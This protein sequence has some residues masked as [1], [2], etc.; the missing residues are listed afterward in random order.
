MK[1]EKGTAGGDS[2][3]CSHHGGSSASN[4]GAQPLQKDKYSEAIHFQGWNEPRFEGNTKNK[5]EDRNWI[6]VTKSNTRRT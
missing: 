2:G 5:K 4:S 3:G 6:M 1:A